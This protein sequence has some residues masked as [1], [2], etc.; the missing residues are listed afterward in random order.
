MVD[1]KENQK[2]GLRTTDRL[3][4]FRSP[5]KLF[6]LPKTNLNPPPLMQLVRTS[7]CGKFQSL[8]SSFY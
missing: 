3:I 6:D 7:P 1:T 8:T 4:A 2:F 5:K